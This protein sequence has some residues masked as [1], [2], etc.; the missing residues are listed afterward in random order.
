VS[1]NVVRLELGRQARLGC[2]NPVGVSEL[3]IDDADNGSN[4]ERGAKDPEVRSVPAN[5]P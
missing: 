3:C 2:K 4:P 1:S 5:L